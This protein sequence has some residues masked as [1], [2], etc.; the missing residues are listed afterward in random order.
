METVT[1]YRHAKYDTPLWVNENRNEGRYNRAGQS[2]TQY[3][4]LHPLGVTAE[5]LRHLGMGA[6]DDLVHAQLR[7]WALQVDLAKVERVNYD[8]CSSRGLTPEQ[9]VGDDY[10]F[11][12]RAADVLRDSG[13][14]GLIAPSAA[15]P[16]TDILVLFG[17]RVALPYLS[18][19]VDR[20]Q[21]P[22]A[23]VID[24]PPAAEVAPSVRWFGQPHAGLDQW[25][26]TG[27]APVFADP[28][29]PRP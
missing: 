10:T 8:N 3:L 25:H 9:L 26:Q 11:T 16:G 20:D 22:T 4:C 13:I 7:V 18:L 24:G 5:F 28:A 6:V 23:H 19:P 29:V 27:V 14:D 1:A 17:P 15:L 2:S 21:I 12:Q